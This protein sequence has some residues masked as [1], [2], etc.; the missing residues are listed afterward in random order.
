MLALRPIRLLS[1][2]YSLVMRLIFHKEPVQTTSWPFPADRKKRT[3]PANKREWEKRRTQ[4]VGA[5]AGV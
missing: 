1:R 3:H 4:G 5:G 2:S